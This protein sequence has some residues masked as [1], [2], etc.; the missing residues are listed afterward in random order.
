MCFGGTV[1]EIYGLIKLEK[2]RYVL[3]TGPFYGAADS[4]LLCKYFPLTVIGLCIESVPRS[5]HVHWGK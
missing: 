4:L 5:A 2:K 3:E 1:A